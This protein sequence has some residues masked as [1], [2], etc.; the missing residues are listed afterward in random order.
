MTVGNPHSHL[1]RHALPLLLGNL[2]QLSYN[3]VDTIIAGR[4]IGQNAPAAEWIAAP[5]MNPVFLA[6]SGLC[7]G[8]GVLMIEAFGAKD[9]GKLQK[10]QA[11]SLMAGF[12][13]CCT[14]ALAGIL[15]TNPFF[16]SLCRL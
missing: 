14:P 6:I 10:I 16:D 12:A 5:V 11:N 13:V 15:F 2:L 4:F 8:S 3:V 7:L 9:Y 1:C